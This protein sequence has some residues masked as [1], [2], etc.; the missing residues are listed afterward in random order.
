MVATGS[1]RRRIAFGLLFGIVS[2][3]AGGPTPVRAQEDLWPRVRQVYDPAVAERIDALVDRARAGGVPA[4]P[5]LEKALEGRAKGVP[6]ERVLAALSGYVDRLETAAGLFPAP[7]TSGSVVA[8]A[9]ALRRGVPAGTI[10][11]MVRVGRAEAAPVALIVL[12]DLVEAGVPP[13]QALDAVARAMAGG[14]ANEALLTLPDVVRRLIRD[15]QSPAD[16]A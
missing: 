2:A 15:G 7:A 8:A 5:I 4:E 13:Q 14:S 9:D 3:G 1:R 6:A 12:G 16:A 11:E 10:G